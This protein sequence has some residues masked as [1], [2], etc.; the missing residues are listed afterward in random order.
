MDAIP[1]LRGLQAFDAA[2]RTGSFVAAAEELHV[3]P[4]A[5]SQLVRTLE[6]QLGR[7]LF[8]RL[9]RRIILTEAGREALPRLA[10]AFEE[11]RNVTRTLRGGE[12]RPSLTVSV[13]PSM[14][15]GWLPRRIASFIALHGLV[16]IS[17]RGEDDPVPFERERI[18]VRLSYGRFHYPE[19]ATQEIVTDAVYPLCS[20]DFLARYGAFDTA[21][22]LLGAPLIHTDWGSAAA[23]YPSWRG[24]FEAQRHR[25]RQAD[26][27]RLTANGSR[28]ALELAERGLGVALG[29]GIYAADMVMEGS[30]VVAFADAFE[31][32]QPYCVTVPEASTHKPIVALFRD[33]FV[34]ECV[35]AVKS[36]EFGARL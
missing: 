8:Q 28:T 23:A 21:E 11:L 2:A 34:A 30:L 16:D 36:P 10:A 7:K 31:L 19:H 13:P 4:A 29:Q 12:T 33:W 9:N 6:D 1:S 3:S 24:W 18:D 32:G 35:N 14:S 27:A 20:K 25:P 26:P 17:M 15:V 22:A 5:I